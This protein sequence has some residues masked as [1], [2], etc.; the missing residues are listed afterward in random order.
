[1]ESPTCIEQKGIIEDIKNS[2]ALVRIDTFSA[3]MSCHAKAACGSSECVPKLVEVEIT[4]EGFYAGEPVYVIMRRALGI[5]AA[6]LA[7]IFPFVLVILTLIT[8]ASL[9]VSELLSGIFSL[10]VLVPYFFT[11]YLFRDNLKK[12]FSFTLRKAD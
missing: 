10:A 3:C 9:H 8:L 6:I 2:K 7:Y 1:M 12:S 5:R 11:I 4:E